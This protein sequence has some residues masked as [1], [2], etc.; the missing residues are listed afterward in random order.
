MF[1]N[2]DIDN[3]DDTSDL[4]E[5]AIECVDSFVNEN[6]YLYSHPKFRCKILDNVCDL[7]NITFSDI[8]SIKEDALITIVSESIEYYFNTIGTPRSYKMSKIINMPDVNI[9]TSKLLKLRSIVQPE[10]KTP[11]WYLFRHNMLTASSIWQALGTQASI[12]RLIYKKCEP[13]NMYKC[14]RVNISSAC[15]HGQKYEPVTQSFYENMYSTKLEEFGCIQHSL[16][17]FI[18][19]SPDGINCLPENPRYGRML[20]I[21]N[22]VNREITGIPK[23]EYWIQMQM[24]ME[25]CDLDEC[26][27]LETRFKEYENYDA[28]T[29][30]GGFDC[31]KIKGI[32]IYFHSTE[33]PVYKYSPFLADEDIC[34]DWIDKCLEDNQTMTWIK[35]IYW[36]LEEYS[37]VLVPR[38]RNWFQDALP[39][40]RKVWETILY[41]REHGYIHRKAK[42]RVKVQKKNNIVIKVRTES[43]DDS[44][45]QNSGGLPASET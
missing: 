14:L 44:Y 6:V 9:I 43:F 35:N 20:E 25:V 41:E 17:K 16:Y 2:T 27:F 5:M 30:D 42:K 18:G 15:H 22:I 11:P 24:Q 40:L 39:D 12:N 37:C 38:N 3:D 1:G 23:K 21:K 28:F 19:A 29:A 8:P 4:C 32:I 34:N 33:G 45:I 10:Q 26:D 31:K 7:L 13:I 36:S